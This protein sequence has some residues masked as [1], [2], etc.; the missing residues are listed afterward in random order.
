MV[1][2]IKTEQNMINIT[3]LRYFFNHLMYGGKN[4]QV[5]F[6]KSAAKS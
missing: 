5:Y 3:H 2:V 1:K 6:Q 4:C